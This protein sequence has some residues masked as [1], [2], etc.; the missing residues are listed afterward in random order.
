[1]TEPVPPPR[2]AAEEEGPREFV[3][4]TFYRL[5][6]EWRRLERAQREAG[7][8]RLAEVID[9]PPSGLLVRT[10]S[11]VGTKAGADFALWMIS[12]ELKP[13]QTL[14]ATISGTP[15]GGYL[16]IAYSYLG[17]AQRSE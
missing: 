7:R 1:M 12:P 9:H 4:Y 15:L 14:H 5:R 6:P 3:K 11:T 17:M 8:R 13:I 16:D 2:T 10:Y